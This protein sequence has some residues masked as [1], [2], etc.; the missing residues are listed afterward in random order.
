M[1]TWT[2]LFW[3]V[4][5]CWDTGQVTV[6]IQLYNSALSVYPL[7]GNGYLSY[8]SS[9]TPSTNEMKPQTI[10][11]NPNDFKNSTGYWRVKIRGT[12]PT[13]TQ[14]LMKV[15]WIDAQTTYSS[16]GSSI[17]YSAWLYYRISATTAGGG[18]VPYA[19]LSIYSNGTNI[20][21]RNAVDKTSV[22]NPAWVRLDANGVYWLEL[23]SSHG[24]SEKFILW[25]VVGSVVGQKTITQESP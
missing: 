21:F 25:A 12:K 13:G 15:D 1:E 5:S 8:V 23:K 14:F 17:P 6:T 2:K 4:Q 3:S 7:S 24:D 9:A 16:S 19:Y 22:V 20:A 11:S 10:A 18:L